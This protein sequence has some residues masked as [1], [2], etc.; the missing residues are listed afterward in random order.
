MLSR[1]DM[2]LDHLRQQ[3]RSLSPQSTLDRGYSVVRD[4]SGRVI[5][6]PTSVPAGAKLMVKLAKGDLAVTA[7]Q[8]TSK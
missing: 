6:D 7:D 5:T 1:E 3:I 8:K 4:D 2:G